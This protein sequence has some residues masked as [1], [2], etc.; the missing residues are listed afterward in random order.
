[1]FGDYDV[2]GATSA[3]L[4]KRYFD[5]VGGEL[6][7]YIPDRLREGY[8][9]NLPALLGLRD[10]GAKLV[11]TVDC[12]TVAFAP[13]AGAAEAGLDTIVVDHHLSESRLP[14][15]AAVVNPNRT[16]DTSGQG[17][18]AAVGVAYLLVIAINRAL[19]RSGWFGAGR[20][21]PDLLQWLDLVALGTI[22]DVVPL[23]GVN[24]ALVHRGLEVMARRRNIGLAAL[25]TSPVS[26]NRPAPITPATCSARGSTPAAGSANR[27]SAPGS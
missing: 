17:Q 21:E 19:R 5:A 27:T 6:V 7:I 23:T 14:P 12:G 24:R 11:I 1:M 4:I 25:A 18:L 22:C 15:A 20:P 8:G 13:L 26:I 2:D 3:A 9:P 10:A 16:D